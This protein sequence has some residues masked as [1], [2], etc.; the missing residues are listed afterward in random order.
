MDDASPG[1]VDAE[2]DKED[3]LRA[4]NNEEF[5]A[6][7]SMTESYSEILNSPI[8]ETNDLPVESNAPIVIP[9]RRPSS[10]SRHHSNQ[11]KC[12]LCEILCC[13]YYFHLQFLLI[14][15]CVSASFPHG[16]LRV[17]E[18]NMTHFVADNIEF[19]IKASSPKDGKL[20]AKY[21]SESFV[22][23]LTLSKLYHYSN[24][25]CSKSC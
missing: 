16:S 15:V 7:A 13:H 10:L 6:K 3:N 18:C 2:D 22:F 25:C 8:A 20:F 24:R 23:F 9:R 4:K 19:K 12:L 11:C 5:L 1:N 14:L 17:D 21:A